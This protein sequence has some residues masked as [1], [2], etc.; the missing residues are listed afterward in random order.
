MQR[1]LTSEE[2]LMM[3]ELVQHPGFKIFTEYSKDYIANLG[4]EADESLDSSITSIL[5]REQKLGAKRYLKYLSVDF[6]NYIKTQNQN[7]DNQ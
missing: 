5:E 2:A 7:Y 4:E 3:S 1:N 6:L